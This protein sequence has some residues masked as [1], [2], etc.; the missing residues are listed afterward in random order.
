LPEHDL[1]A[2]RDH[3]ADRKEATRHGILRPDPGRLRT[4]AAGERDRY[5]LAVDGQYYR[6]AQQVSKEIGHAMLDEMPAVYIAKYLSGRIV[7]RLKRSIGQGRN[8]G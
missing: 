1:T 6:R 7:R 8:A 5:P 4:H 3:L 2:R